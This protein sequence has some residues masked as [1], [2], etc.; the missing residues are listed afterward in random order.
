VPL[1]V[2]VGS[3]GDSGE[4]ES[5]EVMNAL[6]WAKAERGGHVFRFEDLILRAFTAL[7]MRSLSPM[8]VMPISL[9]VSWSSSNNMSPRISFSLKAVTYWGHLLSVNQRATWVSFQVR[10]KSE[11]EEVP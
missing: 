1:L 11:K 2:L 5:R 10:K 8:L 9:R 4:R 3:V 6:E 7:S